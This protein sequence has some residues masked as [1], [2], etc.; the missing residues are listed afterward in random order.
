MEERCF[1]CGKKILIDDEK[2]WIFNGLCN[3][4]EEVKNVI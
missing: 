1:R 2:V 3:T 4:C